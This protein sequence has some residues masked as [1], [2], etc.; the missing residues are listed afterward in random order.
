MACLI[1]QTKLLFQNSK[2]ALTLKIQRSVMGG[3]CRSRS[4]EQ[5]NHCYLPVRDYYLFACR[6]SEVES[7]VEVTMK[8]VSAKE[9]KLLV[10]VY[11]SARP[12]VS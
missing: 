8:I 2:K 7:A 4:R 9:G 12:C 10:C 3:G 1:V 5:N 6:T 11:R